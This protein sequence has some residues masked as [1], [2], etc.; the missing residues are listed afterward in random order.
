VGEILYQSGTDELVK[1][2]LFLLT[3]DQM[4]SD[5]GAKALLN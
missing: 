4:Y 3:S 1:L 5:Y 2:G